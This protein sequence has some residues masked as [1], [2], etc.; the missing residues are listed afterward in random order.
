MKK[1]AIF[2]FLTFL[3]PH[4][5]A[6]PIER[7][8]DAV[9]FGRKREVR[10]FI[11]Q[12]GDVNE[13][14][15]IVLPLF[16]GEHT[17]T[18]LHLAI[19]NF[20]LKVAHMLLD[21][22]ASINAR[23]ERNDPPL[24]VAMELYEVIQLSRTGVRKRIRDILKYETIKDVIGIVTLH[25][26]T[27]RQTAQLIWFGGILQSSDRLLKRIR[28][29]IERMLATPGLEVN[30]PD[31][32]TLTLLHQ[33]IML[34]EVTWVQHLVEL[35]ANPFAKVDG[36]TARERAKKLSEESDNPEPYY[37]IYQIVRSS[38]VAPPPR[39]TIELATRRIQKLYAHLTGPAAEPRS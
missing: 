37:D 25:P 31:E 16:M 32:N 26:N 29:I 9:R 38:T 17:T 39:G 33:A 36:I 8:G 28:P 21:N 34:G 4:V 19:A 35:G 5:A 20:H 7:V 22:G 18:L 12:G 30:G 3:M 6:L 2:S 1:I 11:E 23:D 27:T 13:S 15:T 14:V 24:L 10:R